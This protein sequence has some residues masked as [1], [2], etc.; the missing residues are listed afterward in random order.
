MQIPAGKRVPARRRSR[1]LGGLL[2][3]SLLALL[4]AA[5]AQVTIQTQGGVLTRGST[6]VTL[7]NLHA[8][9]NVLS[10]VNRQG[11]QLIPVCSQVKIEALGRK[12]MSFSVAGTPGVFHY[13]YHGAA[14]E[15]FAQHLA[16]YF[17]TDCPRA[18]IGQLGPL[19]QRGIKEGKPYLGMTKEGI[20]LAMGLPPRHRT[21]NL[22][23][24]SWRY[25]R[26]KRGIAITFDDSGRMIGAKGLKR[27]TF[28]TPK[29][30]SRYAVNPRRA[31]QNQNQNRNRNAP[32]PRPAYRPPPPP[33]YQQSNQQPRQ[34]T[35][36][37][38]K[39]YSKRVAVVV[40]INQY[41]RWPSLAG[42]SN[43]ARRVADFLRKEGFDEVIEVYDG[44]ATRRRMLRVLGTELPQIADENT[45]AMIY[46]AGHGQTETLPGGG[47]RGYLIPVDAETEDVFSTAISMDTVR[48]LSKRTPAKHVYYAIDACYSGL[49]LTRG[50]T[51]AGGG[52]P[53]IYLQK[54][55]SVPAVQI[56]TAG[57]DGE[58]AIEIGGQGIFT[59]YLLRAM[60]G[61]ADFNHDGAVT[62]SEIGAFVKPQVTTASRNQQT[63]QFGTME[64]SGEVVF[65]SDR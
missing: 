57:A 24:N 14:A 65:L 63:P 33:S 25:W 17:G 12:R 59:T 6:A 41:Q 62:A 42:A 54:I 37:S 11:D 22:Q 16:R 9:K 1:H 49:A 32:P 29:D 19:D 45:L 2:G 39:L 5:C 55:T 30:L 10:A 43:D 35:M 50:I 44:D 61:E 23:S 40:G 26:G 46:F 51:R 58:Q 64:G 13:N 31:P 3:L 36:P 28:E 56:I 38:G 20:T 4:A 21:P 8:A 48:D 47:K 27:G 7:V 53:N 15:P 52:P 34:A 18:R 60:G